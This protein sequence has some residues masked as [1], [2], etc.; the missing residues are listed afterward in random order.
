[1]KTWRLRAIACAALVA[2]LLFESGKHAMADDEA[3][4]PPARLATFLARLLAYDSNLKARAK[5]GVG[6]AVLYNGQD[7]ASATAGEAMTAAVK[8]LELTRILDLPIAVYGVPADSVQGLTEVV[9]SRGIDTIIVAAGLVE[10]Q[11]WILSVSEKNSALTV[12]L[13]SA[14]VRSGIAVGI[15]LESGKS[16]I[17][18]NLPASKRARAAFS[19][20]LLRLSEV[21]Q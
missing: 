1:M 12:G 11:P 18:I 16:K 8:T 13:T 7:K 21:I 4:M 14:Q 10:Q 2:T 5:G 17:L 6:I 15:Y 9:Q 3:P 20:D 19:A